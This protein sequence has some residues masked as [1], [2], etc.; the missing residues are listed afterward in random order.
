VGTLSGK[1]FRTF[2]RLLSGLLRFL[3][4]NLQKVHSLQL[5]YI[6]RRRT[7]RLDS[8]TLLTQAFFLT[9]SHDYRA[10]RRRTAEGCPGWPGK[11]ELGCKCELN[12]RSAG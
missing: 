10:G 5:K 11:S 1:F 3:T 12:G 6:Y 2:Q 8:T 7:C 4:E 9:E